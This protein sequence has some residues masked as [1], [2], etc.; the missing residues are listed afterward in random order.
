MFSSTH[1][2]RASQSSIAASAMVSPA[3]LGARVGIVVVDP[4]GSAQDTPV[5]EVD[6]ARTPLQLI[7]VLDGPGVGRPR[8]KTFAP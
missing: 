4:S 1:E 2:G 5:R 8:P 7:E 3:G 6:R